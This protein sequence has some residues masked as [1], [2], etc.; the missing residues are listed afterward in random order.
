MVR[1]VTYN[2]E[3]KKEI[4]AKHAQLSYCSSPQSGAAQPSS[5]FPF[6]VDNGQRRDS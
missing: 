6:A 1:K 2:G 4:I 3:K 5:E